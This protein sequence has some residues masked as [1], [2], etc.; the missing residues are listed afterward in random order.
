MVKRLL[1]D[2]SHHL[3]RYETITAD[4]NAVEYVDNISAI[5]FACLASANLHYGLFGELVESPLL[6]LPSDKPEDCAV[7]THYKQYSELVAVPRVCKIVNLVR[8]KEELG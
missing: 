1:I 7:N 5:S 6:F 3:S 8:Y 2:V 4:C